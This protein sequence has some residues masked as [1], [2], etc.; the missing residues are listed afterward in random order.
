MNENLQLQFLRNFLS[1]GPYIL[2]S[3]F[4]CQYHSGSALILPKS[5]VRRRHCPRLSGNVHRYIRQQLF[6]QQQY[7]RIGNNHP[8]QRTPFQIVQEPL[9]LIILP[10]SRKGVQSQIELFFKS[11]RIP[12][13]FVQFL[14]LK[15]VCRLPHSEGFS[16]TIHR[17]RPVKKR[18]LQLFHISCG[19]EQ[20]RHS[21]LLCQALRRRKAI[22]YGRTLPYDRFIVHHFPSKVKTKS[23]F[24]KKS[25]FFCHQN[26]IYLKLMDSLFLAKPLC[27]KKSPAGPQPR[28]IIFCSG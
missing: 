11:M 19:R 13:R 6:G 14:C 7:S 28:S 22:F 26:S 4:P 10:P 3:Q 21:Y 18:R 15:I 24:F 23:C 8:V 1:D 5:A 9:Q 20:F 17:I 16:R 2:K 12:N 27:Q 25:P